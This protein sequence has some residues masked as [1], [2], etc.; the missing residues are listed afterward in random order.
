MNFLDRSSMPKFQERL[1]LAASELNDM[2]EIL[3]AAINEIAGRHFILT[4]MIPAEE[5]DRYAEDTN[6]AIL[7]TF[8]GML[9]RLST[10]EQ[11][12]VEI[13]ELRNNDIAMYDDKYLELER[14]LNALDDAAAR[15]DDLNVVLYRT[16]DLPSSLE[17]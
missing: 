15:K 16:K 17:E 5:R 13:R 6:C 2:E 10:L 7:D 1:D 12:I 9:Q 3:C 4:N 14:R 11:D 8:E